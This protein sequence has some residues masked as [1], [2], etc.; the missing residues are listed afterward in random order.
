[1]GTALSVGGGF[2]WMEEVAHLLFV[3][4]PQQRGVVEP[5]VFFDVLGIAAALFFSDD[6]VVFLEK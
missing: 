5:F 1:M 3:V 4:V 6:K 2:F